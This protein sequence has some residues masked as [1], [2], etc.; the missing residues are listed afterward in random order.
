MIWL[1]HVFGIDDTSGRWYGFWSGFGSDLG[2]IA[3]A[4]AFLRAKNCHVHG[5]WRIGRHPVEGTLYTTCRRHHPAG[6][7]THEHIHKAHR[8]HLARTQAMRDTVA[9]LRKERP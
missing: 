5:C 3:G 2:L 7:P 4:A 6:A 8:A 9:R 1:L